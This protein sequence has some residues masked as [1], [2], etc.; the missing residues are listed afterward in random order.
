MSVPDE[1]AAECDFATRRDPR[2]R[3]LIPMVV[4]VAF[5]MEQLDST[6][7]TTAIPDIATSL[8]A[9]PVQMNLAVT[10]Y[11]LALAIF[12]PVSG[13]FADRFGARRTFV[14]ALAV[15]TLGS[16]AC[17]AAWSLPMLVATRAVQGLGG[18][19]MTPVGRLILLRSF[20][21]RD[22][23]KAMTYTT[24]PAILGPVAGPLLG[25][26]ITTY[27]SWRWIFL[28][29]VPFGLIGIL[30]AL[31]F[32]EDT[33]AEARTP[34]DVPG[35]L[36]VGTAV[37]MIQL[38]LE[39]VGKPLVPTG[40]VV[41]LLAAATALLLAFGVHAPRVA[42]P[43]VDLRLFRHRSFAV[44]T[45]AGGLCRVGLN[46]APFL[47]P[48]MLQVGFGLSPVASGSL[49]FVSSVGAIPVRV[50]AGRLLR[51]FGFRTVL[52][53]SAVLGA[54]AVAGFAALEPSTPRWI[55]AGYILLFGLM[56]STQFMT[57]NTLSYADLPAEELSRATSVGG[58]LQQLSVSFG[59]STAAMVLGLLSRHGEALTVAGF[60][61]AFLLTAV[62]PLLALPG[63]LLLKA[64]DGA[65][66][67]G[68]RVGTARAS[69]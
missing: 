20:P 67:S 12:I 57:S 52:G 22:L 19:M 2:L 49:T 60:H 58:V 42:H 63:F 32:V 36:L 23:V 25:G 1:R 40:A 17:G 16:V 54:L 48:L 8:R 15:F 26:L 3:F 43:A 46:G 21:R 50:V 13:W 47:L 9:T 65:Q 5:L 28:V 64:E 30:L 69:A 38:A 14:A 33:R 55:L 31:R 39:A 11:V 59:V 6:I 24:L 35:F 4:A 45:L 66:V 27:A 62:V 37:A 44:G 29:N 7:I 61:R 51:W 41:V 56:R 10:T 34:F 18:A 53:G 68:H